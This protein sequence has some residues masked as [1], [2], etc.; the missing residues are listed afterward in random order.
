L[1]G[2][3]DA[4]A[5]LAGLAEKQGVHHALVFVRDCP[6]WQ[7]YGTV[8]WRNTPGLD[9]DV[10]WARDLGVEPDRALLKE[11][12]GRQAYLAD[13]LRPAIVPMRLG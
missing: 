2:F 10:V 7:C 4:D 13:Y 12:P 1:R 5:R 3:N 11:F 6:H 9:G 8:F